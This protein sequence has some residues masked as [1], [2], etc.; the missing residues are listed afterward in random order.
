[1]YGRPRKG[2]DPCSRK[3]ER[4]KNETNA[5][6]KLIFP[7]SEAL[8]LASAKNRRARTS[9]LATNRTRT[10]IASVTFEN[11]SGTE[12]ES[13]V[14]YVSRWTNIT[15]ELAASPP[16]P[17]PAEASFQGKRYCDMFEQWRLDFFVNGN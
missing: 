4:G 1:M 6:L 12:I 9:R 16:R 7:R 3:G 15:T 13:K 10:N 8:S 5:T 17:A 14:R 11:Y 2:F